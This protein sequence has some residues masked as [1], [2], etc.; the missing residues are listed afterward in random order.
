MKAT[1]RYTTIKAM[2]H[3]KDGKVD[4]LI[5]TDE[6]FDD[7][8]VRVTEITHVTPLRQS[9]GAGCTI[10]LTNDK[11]LNTATPIDEL[12][13]RLDAAEEKERSNSLS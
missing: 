11:R 6:P 13:R 10:H 12:E 3:Y 2:R 1:I 7:A 4:Y 9:D 8:I 5:G